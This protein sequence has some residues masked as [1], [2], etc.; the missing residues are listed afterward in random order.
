MKQAWEFAKT[1]WGFTVAF[2]FMLFATIMWHLFGDNAAAVVMTAL[3]CLTPV[4]TAMAILGVVAAIFT[5]MR[6]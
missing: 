6:S 4:A 3:E 2:G 5:A 1:W